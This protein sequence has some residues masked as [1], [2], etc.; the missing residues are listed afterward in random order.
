MTELSRII[1]GASG[2]REAFEELVC[3]IA[4]RLPPAGA[5]EF[6]RIHGAGG[7]GG[8]EA[9]WVLADGTEVGYQAKFYTSS[10]AIDWSAIDKSVEAA[11][12][13][14]PLLKRMVIAIACAL[15]G[16]TGRNTKKGLPAANGWDAWD[17]R[18]AKWEAMAAAMGRTVVFEPWTAP[19]IEEMLGRPATLGLAALWLGRMDLSRDWLDAQCGRTIAA[20]EERYHPEDHVDVTARDAFDGLLRNT[21]FKT[22]LADA[23]GRVAELSLPHQ[24]RPNLPEASRTLLEEVDDGRTALAGTITEAAG[25]SRD[26]F[27]YDGWRQEALDLRGK[28]FEAI[29]Q[30]EAVIRA[31][32]SSKAAK[33]TT[34]PRTG[35]DTSSAE[36]LLDSL[37]ELQ[38]ALGRLLDL[39]DAMGAR[40]DR[41][42]F[43][44][45]EGR[46]G[47]GKSHLIASQVETALAAG[48]AALFA[49]GTDFSIHGT[50]ENQLLG[51]FELGAG[52]FDELLAALDAQA[53]SSGTRALIAIDAVNEGAGTALWRGALQGFA[54]RVLAH[55]NLAL[56]VSCRT[57]YTDQLVTPAVGSMAARVAVAGFQTTEEIEA[58]AKV[59]LDRRGIVRPATPWLNPEFSNPL[60]LRTTCLALESEGKTA[61][62]RG[63]RGT[64]EVLSFY[65]ASTARHLGTDYDGSDTL[66]P[67][68]RRAMVAIAEEMASNSVDYVERDR[69]NEI[70]EGVF[71][72]FPPPPGRSFLELLRFRGL[73]RQD[74][75]PLANAANPLC[76]RVDVLRFS[77]QRFQ[78]HLMADALLKSL[79][80]PDG[81]LD[82]GGALAFVIDADEI[83]WEWRGLFYA[84]SLQFPERFGVEIVDRLPGGMAPWWDRWPVQDAFADSIRWRAETAF[85]TRTLELLNAMDRYDADL[86]ALLVELAVVQEHPWNAKL[87]DRNLRKRALPER[88]AFWTQSINE[89]HHDDGHPLRRLI[90]WCLGGGI[91]RAEDVTLQLALLVLGWSL[92]STSARTRDS[93]TKA[94]IAVLSERP[95]LAGW[96]IGRFGG[97][98][99]P[100]VTE[101]MF[102]ALYGASLRT[103]DPAALRSNALAAW[104]GAFAGEA[105]PKHILTRDYARGTI[106]LAASAGC[107]DDVIDLGRCRPPYGAK[108]AV[109]NITEARV[110][111][112][113]ERLGAQSILHSCYKGLADFGRYTLEPLVR[114]FAAAKLGSPRPLTA[115]ESGAAFLERVSER[116]PEVARAFETVRDAHR[117]K[118]ISFNDRSFA[119]TVPRADRLKIERAEAALVEQ[120]G[121]ADARAYAKEARRWAQG[122]DEWPGHEGGRA[123]E[124]DTHRAKLWVANRAM[125][126]GWNKRR[127]P[128]DLG[129]DERSNDSGRVERIGKKYQRIALMELLARLAD[130][131]WIKPDWGDGA[132]AYDTPLDL[133]FSRDVEL[134]IMP[135]D[136]EASAG[137][138]VPAVPRLESPELAPGE[139]KAWVNEPGLAAQRLSLAIGCDLEGGGWLSLYRFA[140]HDV[141]MPGRRRIMDVPWQQSDFHFLAML[142]VPTQTVGRLLDETEANGDDFH[143]WLPRQLVDGPYIGELGRR[144]T[145]PEDPWC[146]LSSRGAGPERSYKVIRPTVSW[147]WESHLDESLEDGFARQ[148][149][150]PWLLT[151]LGLRADVGNEG[152]YRDA[153]DRAVVV[154]A[155]A[156]GASHV[157]VQRAPLE[158][159]ARRHGLEPVWTVIGERSAHLT[160]GDRR[161]EL[162]TRYNGTLVL[163]GGTPVTRHWTEGPLE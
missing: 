131:N 15:T 159:M 115:A 87:L 62:P 13:T 114:R 161:P 82:R 128:Q 153:E 154:T 59:Y 81:T 4:R 25:S 116:R 10:G 89:A 107:L 113:A 144:G 52:S 6:R 97:C 50:I 27:D 26:P 139:R 117:N 3:Q 127:F 106:E 28:D 78:D 20:L 102:A 121:P 12:A 163:D 21:R 109:F 120:L 134:S 40:C 37:R 135:G 133:E 32:N 16:R 57:E 84:L 39:I 23:A 148:V 31:L 33:A 51:R 145:W 125:A 14:H 36:Y 162:F 86:V 46:A 157:L 155:R 74:P 30:M 76:N 42:R 94:M 143:D 151:E 156:T 49:L 35:V 101:R 104:Q 43:L 112:R 73:L 152:V 158:D 123:A 72:G 41:S 93:A 103:L 67:P 2:Q 38:S 147:L 34:K 91:A 5:A 55:P 98:D 129:H 71:A 108:P 146:T 1:P 83:A 24:S 122:Y 48:G 140:S 77:F 90:A 45:L 60:F 47:S 111:A 132:K 58:S 54:T 19:D 66:V 8:V 130:N 17:A 96:L 29:Q 136:V 63:L 119:V 7:D 92:S 61:F 69:A 68:V 138:S 124:V 64:K 9:V 75:H 142:L 22:L 65:L 44:L 137:A 118:R 80:T 110:E 160:L 70:V 150:I 99:D 85:T 88:D 105:P 100:Y 56:C 126:L 18:K 141:E 11:L 95:A 149:P 53:E 79:S